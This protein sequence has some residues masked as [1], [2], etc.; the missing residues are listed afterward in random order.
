MKK[1]SNPNNKEKIKVAIRLRPYLEQ[2]LSADRDVEEIM[3]HD[4]EVLSVQDHRTILTN[5]K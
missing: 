2:E 5:F 3:M 4:K 1:R